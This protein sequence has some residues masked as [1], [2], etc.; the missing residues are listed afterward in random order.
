MYSV[1]PTPQDVRQFKDLEHESLQARA[2]GFRLTGISNYKVPLFFGDFILGASAFGASLLFFPETDEWDISGRFEYYR[3]GSAS[4]GKKM[5]FEAGLELMGYSIGEV[6]VFE[7]PVDLSFL[8]DFQQD[9]LLA[10]RKVPFGET[11]TYAELAEIAGHPGKGGRAACVIRHN[12]L[13]I[14]I[15]CHRVIPRDK[16]LGSYC[17]HPE[18][19]QFLLEHEGVK[20]ELVLA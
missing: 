12:P 10:C 20:K 19:K 8:T 14:L 1:W 4:T 3:L 6:K 5:A 15:P 2:A 16:R 9:V 17:G 11:V 13:P 18:W 7:T